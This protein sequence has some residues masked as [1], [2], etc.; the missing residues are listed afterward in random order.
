MNKGIGMLELNERN[1]PLNVVTTSS[2]AFT[3]ELSGNGYKLTDISPPPL[4]KEI[5]GFKTV[6]MDNKNL[7]KKKPNYEYHK[8]EGPNLQ[9]DGIYHGGRLAFYEVDP[10]HYT[11]TKG[12]IDQ[13]FHTLE[14]GKITLR[15]NNFEPPGKKV[16]YPEEDR[17][18]TLK[19]S[20]LPLRIDFINGEYS[21]EGRK[22]LA[23]FSLYKVK[24]SMKLISMLS[25]DLVE[26]D[27]SE[28]FLIKN[29]PLIILSERDNSDGMG[30]T[31]T[32][33]VD[34]L[35]LDIE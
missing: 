6:W 16:N 5:K 21:F 8:V 1:T 7:K 9:L 19:T 34:D 15:I 10:D 4:E 20:G 14:L 22:L 13:C 12:T 31:N 25:A 28:T 32:S 26:L 3:I 27:C 23:I 29:R 18:F 24:N 30:N 17:S 2:E 33:F 11:A 35:L